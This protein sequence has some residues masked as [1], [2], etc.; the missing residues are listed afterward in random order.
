[1]RTDDTTTGDTSIG[2]GTFT[3][4]EETMAEGSVVE[5]VV[6]VASAVPDTVALVDGRTRLTFRELVLRAAVVRRLVAERTAEVGPGSAGRA[7][8]GVL[9]GHDTGAVVAMLGAAAAGAPLIVLDPT[10]PVPRLRRYVE[11]SG[12]RVV[13]TDHARADL[14]AQLGVNV[15]ALPEDPAGPAGAELPPARAAVALDEAVRD[16][17][18]T[19]SDP[20]DPFVVVYT[21]G[22]TGRPKGVVCS[23]RSV[24]HDAWTNG[25]GTGCYGRGDRVAH[26]LPM[27]F[28]AGVGL[29][30]ATLLCGAE[31][32]L[33]DP[34][35]RSIAELPVWLAEHEITTLVASPAILRGLVHVVPDGEHL[36]GL[37]R[38]T[39]AGETVFGAELER[40]RALV[41][42]ECELRNRYGSTE[43]WLLTEQVFTA[44]TPTPVGAAPVGR[45]VPGVSVEVVDEHGTARP[46]GTGRIR[47]TSRWL[48]DGYLDEPALTAAVFVGRG[49]GTRSYLTSDVGT[50]ADDGTLTLL[51]RTDHSVKI[52]GLL[53]EPGEVD[54]VLHAD[55]EIREAVTVGVTPGPGARPR[56]VAYVVSSASRPSASAVRSLVRAALPAYMVPEQVVFLERLPRNERGKLDRAA[57]PAPP[58][59][60][61]GRGVPHSD[62]ERVVTEVFARVLELDAL[63][64]DDDFFAV[65]G[66]SL[67]AEAL[68]A[69]VN[70]ELGVA[71]DVLTTTTL[72]QASTPR[73]FA[74]AVRG[75]RR[76]AG[77]TIPLRESGSRRPLF[78][79]AGAG[80]IGIAFRALADRIDPEVPVHALQAHGM[81]SRGVPDWSVERTARRYLAEIRRVQPRGPYRLSGH[82]FGGL[83][84]LEMAIQLRRAGEHAELL[85]VI[86]SFP[87][88]PDLM[89]QV[90]WGG[91]MTKLRGVVAI[92]G[93]GLLPD[94][95]EGPYWRFLRRGMAMQ[96]RY[97]AEVYD[98]PA[99]VVVAR[100]DPEAKERSMW[101]PH[102]AG[103]WTL[104]PIAGDHSSI[105][106]EPHVESLAGVINRTLAALPQ[107]RA[108]GAVRRTPVEAP[109]NL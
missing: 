50:I 102:L 34:R 65:G 3:D 59:V 12:A 95:E 31:Q 92:A 70:S 55:P 39:M 101:E 71:D 98:G 51:G 15:L 1:M 46:R 76:V 104:E 82:S 33:F 89:P 84:A 61:V 100:D 7:P 53:V 109:Q 25:I 97:R 26:L 64:P 17:R 45:P 40:L 27:S 103:R 69:A 23:H 4:L 93:A 37:A 11:A 74:A 32:H 18:A 44:R 91:P 79:I 14:A 87:P 73:A 41:G 57:L 68:L 52:R 94:G 36:P 22:S 8:V 106:R 62:W 13:L 105:L 35:S 28:S 90:L 77:D 54:A 83:V 9:Q 78:V 75:G 47:I 58:E 85:V 96:R 10:V 24:L 63:G 43:T 42:P 38:V 48:S 5:R 107:D 30:F 86:D 19:P 67:A 29:T 81:E 60:A 49:D 6:R 80:G 99:V 88:N 66:D 56:L 20:G 72:S 2:I 16:L 21:S 108:D